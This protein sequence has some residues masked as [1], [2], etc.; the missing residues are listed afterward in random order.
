M[1][2]HRVT[3]AFERG[4]K[5]TD[6]A[7]LKAEDLHLSRPINLGPF[8]R[9]KLIN[10]SMGFRGKGERRGRDEVTGASG[11]SPGLRLLRICGSQQAAH[12]EGHCY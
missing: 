11:R 6:E 4:E 8:S 1:N 9:A 5:E 3:F 7:A 2:G 10:E 12:C